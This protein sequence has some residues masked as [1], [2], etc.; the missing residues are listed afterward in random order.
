MVS[1]NNR[2]LNSALVGPD[3]VRSLLAGLMA[4]FT[5][6]LS[7]RQGIR[8]AQSNWCRIRANRATNTAFG[9]SAALTV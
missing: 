3:N 9:Q 7:V 5:M 2:I 1:V 4:S 6:H 8:Q